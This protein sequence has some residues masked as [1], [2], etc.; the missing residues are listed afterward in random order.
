MSEETAPLIFDNELHKLLLFRPG[1]AMP[2]FKKASEDK[3]LRGHFI[4]AAVGEKGDPGLAEFLGVD[5]ESK[6]PE[7]FLFEHLTHKKFRMDKPISLSSIKALVAAFNDKTLKAHLKASPV[8]PGW[9]SEAVK[10]ISSS[11][12][13]QVV[14]DKEKHVL[15]EIYAPWCGHCKTLEPKFLKAAEHLDNKYSD[16]LVFVKMDGTQNEVEE[17]NVGGFPTVLAFSKEDKTPV[18]L[19]E[20]FQGADAKKIVKEVKDAFKLGEKKR[21][22]EAEYETAAKRFKDA[23]K[24]LKGPLTPAATELDKAATALEK[25]AARKDEL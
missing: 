23:V 6:E 22:G 18:D 25:L 11:Q 20:K 21:V 16:D 19:S 8:L 4:F 17:I 13:E 1:V 3:E 14:M 2:E 12:W 15:V 5:T 24:A 10:S 7:L 9:D